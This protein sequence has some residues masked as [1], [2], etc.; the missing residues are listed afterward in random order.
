ML[1]K[2]L[3]LYDSIE[4]ALIK[5]IQEKFI[6]VEES[7]VLEDFDKESLKR[8]C[9]ALDLL[10]I[11]TEQLSKEDCTLIQADECKNFVVSE[12]SKLKSRLSL[13]LLFNLNKRFDERQT[14]FT[15]MA[16][17]LKNKDVKNI[18]DV[19]LEIK[20]LTERI[21]K[22]EDSFIDSRTSLEESTIE[23]D[24]SL[25]SE[26]SE[27][28]Y[29]SKW[30]SVKNRAE[31]ETSITEFNK[32]SFSTKIDFEIEDFVNYNKKG[33]LLKMLENALLTVRPSTV[34]CERIFSQSKLIIT[35]L[36]TNLGDNLVD[37]IIFM[38]Y[39]FLNKF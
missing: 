9:Q 27:I 6:T 34:D 7:K 4:N 35:N 32:S 20:M 11:L 30:L 25:V 16:R 14:K 38:K 19:K 18:E 10:A 29:R 33:N 23:S 31:K 1:S 2:F 8:P 39:Y 21:Y 26:N 12:L 22:E 5:C 15:E 13:D 24:L 17:F 3:R 37:D 36:R 28:D